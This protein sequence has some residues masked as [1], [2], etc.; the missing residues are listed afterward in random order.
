MAPAVSNI[1]PSF[2]G[3]TIDEAKALI[4]SVKIKML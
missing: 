1:E 4:Q 2:T 3:F